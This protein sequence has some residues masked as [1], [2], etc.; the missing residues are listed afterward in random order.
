VTAPI[1]LYES[2]GFVTTGATETLPERA[3]GHGDRD[4]LDMGHQPSAGGAI[5]PGVR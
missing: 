5:G 2:L 1:T 3:I 4:A